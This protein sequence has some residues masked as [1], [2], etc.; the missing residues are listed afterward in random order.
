LYEEKFQ[1]MKRLRKIL[2]VLILAM[3]KQIAGGDTCSHTIRIVIIRPNH[4]GF[5]QSMKTYN[6][7]G[8]SSPKGSRKDRSVDQR[9]CWNIDG[10]LK[11]IT[12]SMKKK[13]GMRDLYIESANK[14]DGFLTEKIRVTE[15]N[16]D[17]PFSL[18]KIRGEEVLHYSIEKS[19]RWTGERSSYRLVY[20]VIDGD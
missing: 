19:K 18:Y 10:Y 4:V 7:V 11:R 1:I 12:V 2:F 14:G 17:L 20:T 16:R 15:E 3:V 8:I 6:V 9:I 13:E 5:G